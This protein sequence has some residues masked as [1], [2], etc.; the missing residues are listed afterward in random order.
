[1]SDSAP[2]V[3]SLDVVE[4]FLGVAPS[5]EQINKLSEPEITEMGNLVL[6]S[7][8]S[9]AWDAAPEGTTYPGGWLANDMSNPEARSYLNLAL[10]YYPKILLHDPLGDFFFSSYDELPDFR[11]L[12]AADG[13]LSVTTGPAIWHSGIER[14]RG[15]PEFL[16]SRLGEIV[17]FLVQISPLI[18]EGVVTLRSQW[19]T[20]IRQSNSLVS[21]VRHDAKDDEL[22]TALDAATL[23]EAYPV[24]DNIRGL[25]VLPVAPL[26][27]ADKRWRFQYE[28][29]YLAKTL[30]VA[31][32]A[33][34]TYVPAS[35]IELQVLRTRLRHSFGDRVQELQPIDFLREVARVVVP[36]LELSPKMAVAM[37]RSESDFDDWHRSL[38]RIRRST[39]P[40]DWRAQVEDELIPDIRRVER[41]MQ[42][43][44]VARSSLRDSVASTIISGTVSGLA[45]TMATGSPVVAVSSAFGSGILS[46]LWKAYF[47]PSLGGRDSVIAALVRH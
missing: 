16:R 26:R 15:D 27:E 12:R 41:A 19:P 13:R 40:K 11:P 32:V 39:D 45:A 1:M 3:C 4:N 14:L 30:A 25:R 8:A 21:S 23:Q 31:D 46:W 6:E 37:R 20:I 34:A 47:P 18:R 24:W 22:L 44:P 36:D 43:S 5:I 17:E 35:E 28:S 38:D 10:L 29:F 7:C 42:R 33:A 9:S 2:R